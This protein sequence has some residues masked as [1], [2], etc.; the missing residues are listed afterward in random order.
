MAVFTQAEITADFVAP[1]P[2]S[3]KLTLQSILHDTPVFLNTGKDIIQLF[4]QHTRHLLEM[5][6]FITRRYS[7]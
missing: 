2:K 6:F 3:K 7:T 4:G 1:L 5:H